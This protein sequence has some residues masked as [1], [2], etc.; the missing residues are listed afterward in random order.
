LPSLLLFSLDSLR[1]VLFQLRD[2]EVLREIRKRDK[3]LPVIA[4]SGTQDGNIQSVLTDDPGTFFI[5]KWE[6]RSIEELIR[7]V[8][9]VL[10]LEPDPG[11]TQAFIVHGHN[12]KLKLELKN[13]LQNTLK[14]PEPLIL[15][16]Q[17]SLGR[18]I[19]DK[20][21]DY[22]AFSSLVF[23]LLMRWTPKTGPRVKMDF[24]WSAGEEKAD[25]ES[26]TQTA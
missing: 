23:V 14:L 16:E 21:E 22:A 18:T 8:N 7:K 26:Q 19:I 15:H 17:P 6:N 4:Y 1:E 5:S 12:D 10:G 11:Q 24:C 9:S 25:Y 13:Y 3:K 20:F 2:E